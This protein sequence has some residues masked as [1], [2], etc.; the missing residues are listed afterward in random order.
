MCDLENQKKYQLLPMN[1]WRALSLRGVMSLWMRDRACTLA[2]R[3]LRP[4]LMVEGTLGE[5]LLIASLLF[6]I[7]RVVCLEVDPLAGDLCFFI[8]FDVW[9]SF[10]L[11]EVFLAGEP[12]FFLT[13]VFIAFT[14]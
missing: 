7:V 8:C 1:S 11:L 4:L 5:C 10:G 6:T 13:G 3:S 2:T 12:R 9:L 14:G